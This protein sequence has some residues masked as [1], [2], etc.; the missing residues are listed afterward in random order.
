MPVTQERVMT[1]ESGAWCPTSFPRWKRIL[2]CTIVLL[3]L[4]VWL[5]LTVVVMVWIKMV[6][7]GPVFYRQER[8]GYRGRP[9]MLFKFRTMHVNAETQTHEQ[10]LARLI[11]ENCPMQKLD[12][13][14]DSR[15][16][17]GGWMIRGAGLDELP[18]VFNVLLGE[19]TLVGP[20]PCLPNEF[21]RYRVDQRQRVNVPPGL[22]GYWQV[23]GK[24][25]VTFSDMIE[26]DRFYA[27]N[28][29]LWLD[30]KIILKTFPVL[31]KEA[32]KARRNSRQVSVPFSIPNFR[33]GARSDQQ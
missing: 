8:V 3:T 16:I 25:E 33:V 18:Q 4:P 22:T 32:R 17:R 19:M 11:D 29:S 28:L 7:D 20:R 21:E 6:S 5:L 14:G 9:F 26:M 12:V 31:I 2:D 30:L 13:S 23:N 15:V 27:T 10:H 24:N 1:V